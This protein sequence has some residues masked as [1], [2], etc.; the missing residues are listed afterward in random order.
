[1][2]KYTSASTRWS[3]HVVWAYEFNRQALDSVSSRSPCASNNALDRRSAIGGNSQRYRHQISQR[4]STSTESKNK[5]S[6]KQLLCLPSQRR[7]FDKYRTPDFPGRRYGPYNQHSFFC[8][9]HRPQ[10][11][12]TIGAG[13]HSCGDGCSGP[14]PLVSRR[15]KQQRLVHAMA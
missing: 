9:R 13:T 6:R 11:M 10:D 3:I 12:G 2:R 1:M 8:L 7:H 5:I 4:N 14:F 15:F